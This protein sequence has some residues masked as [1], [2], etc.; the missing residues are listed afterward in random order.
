M[1]I[2]VWKRLFQLSIATI[3]A[4]LVTGCSSSQEAP[5]NAETSAGNSNNVSLQQEKGAAPD[6]KMRELKD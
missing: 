1:H 2:K 4:I 6:P 3:A 5:V